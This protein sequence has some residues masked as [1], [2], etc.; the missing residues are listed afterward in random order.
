[1]EDFIHKETSKAIYW[2]GMLTRGVLLMLIVVKSTRAP[3]AINLGR[4]EFPAV[5]RKANTPSFRELSGFGQRIVE[6]G[7]C[8]LQGRRGI[9][10]P[11]ND[12]MEICA[13]KERLILDGTEMRVEQYFACDPYKP[14]KDNPMRE[15]DGV[16][17]GLA[18]ET[19]INRSASKHSDW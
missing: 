7:E 18:V 13:V 8:E 10:T 16:R 14:E 6:A 15:P 1:M 2:H 12:L 19:G 5:D 9:Y 11:L 4:P 3:Y 17:F